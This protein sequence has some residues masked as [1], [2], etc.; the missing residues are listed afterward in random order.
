VVVDSD[1]RLVGDIGEVIAAIYYD[2][3]L[4]DVSRHTHDAI[5][6]DGRH[7]QIKA[8]FQ[9]PLTFGKTPDLYLGLKLN[10]DGTYEEVFNGPGK[11]IYDC[12]AKRAGIGQKLIPVSVS[13][14]RGLNEQVAEADRIPRRRL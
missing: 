7:V 8:T 6:S 1:G 4:N 11:M 12:S 3:E 14:L 13:Q 9:K 10:P 2:L 5:T